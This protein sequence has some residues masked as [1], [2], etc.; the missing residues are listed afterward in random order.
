MANNSNISKG[1]RDRNQQAWRTKFKDVRNVARN[2]GKMTLGEIAP[3][4][5]ETATSASDSLRETRQFISK[6]KN[7]IGYQAN[8]LQGNS[9][10]RRARGILKEAMEDLKS[11]SYGL[12]KMSDES[13]DMADNFDADIRDADS[14]IT[15]TSDPNE[16]AMFETRR[17]SALLGKAISQGNATMV[18]GLGRVTR[19]LSSATLKASQA[20]TDQLTNVFLTS[21]NSQNAQMG[22]VNNKLDAINSN[23]VNIVEFNNS[24]QTEF[25]Q[26]TAEYQSNMLEMMS[27][28]GE[29]IAKMQDVSEDKTRKEDEFDFSRGFNLGTYKNMVKKNINNSM[30]GMIGSVGSMAGMMGNPVTMM[31]P[32]LFGAITP[33]FIKKPIERFD[34]SFTKGMENLLYR[35]NDMQYGD[36]IFSMLGEFLGKERPSIA[37]LNMGNY[38][39]DAMSW[40]GKDHKYLTEVIPSYLAKIESGING[41]PE[42]YFNENKGHFMDTRA[43]RKD[44]QKTMTGTYEFSF[45]NLGEELSRVMKKNNID[46]QEAEAI[47]EM[48]NNATKVAVHS[49]SGSRGKNQVR[50]S[51]M[52]RASLQGKV[53]DNSIAY[54]VRQLNDGINEAVVNISHVVD[55]MET[56]YRQLYNQ[57]G[58][59]VNLAN[60]YKG[61]F[62]RGNKYFNGQLIS[63]IDDEAERKKAERSLEYQDGGFKKKI[64]EKALKFKFGGNWKS[65]PKAKAIYDHLVN[66]K[67]LKAN[68]FDRLS[69]ETY[70]KLSGINGKVD[71][72]DAI[73]A[74][75]ADLAKFRDE[76]GSWAPGDEPDQ[77]NPPGID[78]SAKKKRGKRKGY[79]TNVNVGQNN[80]RSSGG[81]GW[82]AEAHSALTKIIPAKLDKIEKAILKLEK[83]GIST[84]SVSSTPNAS[85][86]SSKTQPT[87][88]GKKFGLISFK[89]AL[90]LSSD[91]LEEKARKT[92][93]SLNG[94]NQ[95]GNEAGP[96]SEN[97]SSADVIADRL[98]ENENSLGNLVRATNDNFMAPMVGGIFG[99]EGM[100][101]RFF[102][103]DNLKSIRDKLFDD[104]DGIFKGVG[105][106]FK[107][108]MDYV[109]YVFTGKGYTNRKGESFKENKNSVFD[110]IANGY[111]WVYQKTMQ[112]LF[113]EDFKSNETYKKHFKRFDFKAKRDAKRNKRLGLTQESEEITLDKSQAT[114]SNDLSEIDDRIGELKE[115]ID[116]GTLGEAGLK[117]AN[118]E[119]NELYHKRKSLQKQNKT[120]DVK[121]NIQEAAFSVGQKIRQAGDSLV[122]NVIGKTDDK[123]IKEDRK[124]FG[125]KYKD[126]FKKFLPV[127]IAGALV[128]GGLG[129]L[130]SIQG[131]GAVAPLFFSGGPIAGAVLGVSATILA[132]SEKFQNVLFGEKDEDGNRKNGFISQKTQNFFKKNAPLLVGG[133]ALGALKGVFK[134]VAG[135]A[136][137][138]G[139]GGF[140]MNSLLPGGI[141][142]GAVLGLG[143]S[144]LKSSDRFT[145]ILF[146]NRGDKNDSKT[147]TSISKKLSE[148]FSKSGHFVK[149]GLKGAAI[150]V[151]SGIALNSMGVVGGALSLGGPVGMG[152]LG[153]GMGIA[154][155]ADRVKEMLFGT[156]EFDEEGNSKGRRKNGIFPRMRNYIVM[157]VFE[158]LKNNLQ[159]KTEDF[160]YWIKRKITYP[161]RLAFG[162]IIDS[163]REVRKNISDTI[164]NVFENVGLSITKAVKSTLGVAFKPITRAFKKVGKTMTNVAFAGA[165]MA[166]MPATLPIN[167]VKFGSRNLRKR[168]QGEKT[169]T[170]V[171]H[172]GDIFRGVRDV[173]RDQWAN[174]DREYMAGPLGKIDRFLTHGRDIFRN[175]RQGI[176]AAKAAYNEGMSAQGFNSLGWMNVKDEIKHD[177]EQRKLAKGDR[178][179][180]KGIDEVRK[181]IAKENSHSNI[182]A[183][184]TQLEAYKKRLKKSGLGKLTNLIQTSDDLNDLLY[185]KEDFLDR[186]KNGD[187]NVAKNAPETSKFFQKT[188]DYQEF[189]MN[190]FDVITKTFM[191]YATQNA[192]SRR[193][194]LSIQNLSDIDK[195][196]SQS[197]LTWEDIDMNPGDLADVTTMSNEDWTTY[198]NQVKEQDYDADPTKFNSL[199]LEILQRQRDEAEKNGEETKEL[200]ERFDSLLDIELA[201]AKL[202]ASEQAGDTGASPSEIARAAGHDFGTKF[203]DPV[204]RH[205]KEQ[206]KAERRAKEA[207]ESEAARTGHKSL[208]DEDEDKKNENEKVVE[209]AEKDK[210]G[211]LSG[212]WS[213][214]KGLMGGFGN[215]LGSEKFWKAAGIGTVAAITF[216]PWVADVFGKIKTFLDPVTDFLGEEVKEGAT[217]LSAHMPEITS[218]LTGRIVDNMGFIV[219]NLW[220]ISST[221]VSTIGKK[222]INGIFH[223][224]GL[225]GPFADAE[226]SVNERQEFES[227]EEAQKFA[228][229]TGKNVEGTTSYGTSEYK[230]DEGNV[231]RSGKGNLV[232]AIGKNSFLYASSKAHRSTR[233]LATL[234]AKATIGMAKFAGKTVFKPVT[235]IFGAGKSIIKNTVGKTSKGKAVSN[236]LTKLLKGLKGFKDKAVDIL[237]LDSASTWDKVCDKTISMIKKALVNHP[238]MA[239]KLTAKVASV[240]LKMAGKSIFLPITIGLAAYDAISG[241]TKKAAAYLFGVDED[242]VDGK[243]RTLSALFKVLSGLPVFGWI[244]LIAEIY[245]QISG[246]DLRQEWARWLYNFLPGGDKDGLKDEID[247]YELEYQKYKDDNHLNTD[248]ATYREI[249]RKN[250][251]NIDFDQYSVSDDELA[252]YQRN[253]YQTSNR[254]S[255]SNSTMTDD[256]NVFYQAGTTDVTIDDPSNVGY[257]VGDTGRR[258]R[259]RVVGYGLS[260]SDPRWANYSLGKFPSGRTSTMATGGCGPT[261][262]SMVA[263]NT[264]PL[265]IA[266][267]AK[268]GGYIKDGGATAD[269][270]T[271][272]AK[273]YGLNASTVSKGGLESALKSGQPTIVSGKSSG[274]GPYTENGHVI[275]AQGMDNKGNTLVNDPM[276]GTRKI[277]TSELSKGMTHGWSYSNNVSYGPG[278]DEVVG[279]GGINMMSMGNSMRSNVRES[280]DVTANKTAGE[281]FK[282]NGKKYK[283]VKDALGQETWQE[284]GFFDSLKPYKEVTVPAGFDPETALAKG[285]NA[286][287]LI[288]VDGRTYNATEINKKLAAGD[289]YTTAK[290]NS[291]EMQGV[292]DTLAQIRDK[293]SGKKKSPVTGDIDILSMQDYGNMQLEQL[294]NSGTLSPTMEKVL[295]NKYG[296]AS[297]TSDNKKLQDGQGPN[298]LLAAINQGTL[299]TE[300][301]IKDKINSG[302]QTT[303]GEYNFN[304]ADFYRGLK[305]ADLKAMAEYNS[306]LLTDSRV[307]KFKALYKYYVRSG[308]YDMKRFLQD[309]EIESIFGR[310]DFVKSLGGIGSEGNYE[311]KYG[312]PFFQTDDP[313]WADISW[314]GTTVK[315]RGSDLASLATI[316]T[317]FGPNMLDP[318]YIYDNWIKANE[319]WYDGEKGLKFDKVFSE[320]GY[321]AQK[322]GH[323][324]GQ[325]VVAKKLMSAN[326]IL[327]YLKANKP[328]IMTGYR[329]RGGPFGGYYNSSSAPTNGP[330]DYSTIVARAANDAQMAV[331]NPFTTLHQKGIFDVHTLNDTIGK[332]KIK[333]VKE[334]YGITGPSGGGITGKVD[335]AS[336][337]NQ[338]NDY[339]DISEASGLDKIAALFKNVAN[340]VSNIFDEVLGSKEYVSIFDE[341]E[342]EGGINEEDNGNGK[343]ANLDGF[344]SANKSENIDKS[345]ASANL[346]KIDYSS[347][348]YGSSTS[349]I[350]NSKYGEVQKFANGNTSGIPNAYLFRGNYYVASGP[351]AYLKVSDAQFLNMKQNGRVNFLTKIPNDLMNGTARIMGATVKPSYGGSMGGTYKFT[352]SAGSP[353]GSK[354]SYMV[355]KLVGSNQPL[356]PLTTKYT[357]SQHP[358]V[359]SNST[360]NKVTSRISNWWNTITS[361]RSNMKIYQGQGLGYGG[362]DRDLIFYGPGDKTVGYGPNQYFEY[363]G[364]KYSI[365]NSGRGYSEISDTSSHNGVYWMKVTPPANI[366][367]KI[368]MQSGGSSATA[369]VGSG[370]YDRKKDNAQNKTLQ[371]I[372]QKVKKGINLNPIE[373]KMYADYQVEN[374]ATNT[375]SVLSTDNL[376]RGSSTSS[377]QNEKYEKTTLNSVTTV[378]NDTMDG[379]AAFAG[380]IQYNIPEIQKYIG[381]TQLSS[382]REKPKY[383]AMHYTCSTSSE[384]GSAKGICDY[385][386]TGVKASADWVVDDGEIWQYN[387]DPNASFCWAVGDDKGQPGSGT[388]LGAT[389]IDAGN[390]NTLSIEMQSTNS[391]GTLVNDPTSSTWSISDAVINNSAGLAAK[392]MNDYSI[393]DDNL[394]MHHH[395]SGKLCPGPW[396]RNEKALDQFYDFK[397]KV[398]A[399][400][401]GGGVGTSGSSGGTTTTTTTTGERD[402]SKLPA[403]V[404]MGAIINA[405][406]SAAMG[407]NYEEAKQHY[408]EQAYDQYFGAPE[409]TTTTETTGDTN[410][411][412]SSTFP[413]GSVSLD[414]GD[415]P[416]SIW[417]YFISKGYSPYGTAGIMGNMNHESGMIVNRKQ[418]DFSN[419]YAASEQYTQAA[420]SGAIDF[421]HDSI[422]YGLVQFTY[423]TLKQ[424]LLD[425]AKA[426]GKSVGDLG[427]Q[428]DEIDSY[429]N[430]NGLAG[431]LKTATSVRE[432]SN[433]FLHEYERPADQSAAVEQTRASAGESFFNQ[434][435]NSSVG[436]GL[437]DI[438]QM[439][440]AYMSRNTFSKRSRAVGYGDNWLATVAATKQAVAATGCTYNK[441]GC[442][443]ITVNGETVSMRQDCSGF[444]GAC[445]WFYG[446]KDDSIRTGWTGIYGPENQAMKNGGFTCL[447]WTGEGDLQP[448]DILVSLASHMEI[449]AG[450]G[451]VYNAGSTDALRAPGVTGGPSHSSYDYVW[452]PGDPGSVDGIISSNTEDSS[453]DNTS[454]TSAGGVAGMNTLMDPFSRMVSGLGNIMLQTIDGTPIAF[455]PG[456]AKKPK[457]FFTNTLNGKITS[458]YGKRSSALGNEFHRGVDIAASKGSKIYSPVSGHIVSKG[459]DVAG[460]GNYAVV[461][462][463]KGKNHLFAHMNKE[464]YYGLGD[465]VNQFDVIGEVGST[466]KSTGDHLHYEIRNNGSKYSTID[467]MKYSY[468]N[469][470]SKSLNIN[471]SN[472]ANYPKDPNEAVGSG[473]RDITPSSIADKLEAASNSEV[474]VDK[475]DAIIDA[476]KVM[477]TNTSKPITQPASSTITQNN[478]TVYGVGDKKKTSTKIIE[479]KQPKSTREAEILAN[480]HNT[481]ARRH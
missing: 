391:T 121:G 246:N 364:K 237:K 316:A 144:L 66:D 37:K 120:S 150:G 466:G 460:Y 86:Q 422:G 337:G 301:K 31:L 264:S 415:V 147:K 173:T 73:A 15:S 323:V 153:L 11:G 2:I 204:T 318:E 242:A 399:I 417:N 178:K 139:P 354:Q 355:P 392:I 220:K 463:Q 334:A 431:R 479:T 248:Y 358:A 347:L 412:G 429:L 438:G 29:S 409:T 14:Q 103:K 468:E 213:G 452:R 125:N 385:W 59:K 190:R 89:Q 299:N 421:V 313:R 462:D 172:A 191:K 298:A 245:Y 285:V 455:G 389:A 123:A 235:S 378:S 51:N 224:V 395:V 296:V 163:F 388:S 145:G 432:A 228:D 322:G 16:V 99:K 274:S 303:D 329:Y 182:Y 114:S 368:K 138:G 471:N 100:I 408:L 193:K 383:L 196:L 184:A 257:G 439:Y 272:G 400:K 53:D 458:D 448:G 342:G 454:I 95:K 461:K 56:S 159:E 435:N 48:I 151:G 162:P 109:K 195:N 330:D 430:A 352:T 309:K 129:L 30:L 288:N 132:R 124:K 365:T 247:R 112:H 305:V 449:W 134:T 411:S 302:Y 256:N 333:A 338:T 386:N 201:N 234:P 240:N 281:F 43:L 131:T 434:Y 226:T 88:G 38:K 396:T 444:V 97:K 13:Y 464:S 202:N 477:V 164:K 379:S 75:E 87:G 28:L 397:K 267:D 122:N 96:T 126:M 45:Q 367:A 424:A 473:S 168:A 70:Y 353:T 81:Y 80:Q 50:A 91:S 158:P 249:R 442:I 212:I 25:Y 208:Q 255:K 36:G 160:A 284:M 472:Q 58:R 423:H 118:K 259:K 3:G 40:N 47:K 328:V 359:V 317:A 404:R 108:Q 276:R 336:K 427:V 414:Y 238:E 314:R 311:Y 335:L 450:P 436:N 171:Q 398:L 180:W 295:S 74:V 250:K 373:Q 4:V 377:S 214:F 18:E 197:G 474:I 154:S 291:K 41:T 111:D 46:G 279:Y 185:N 35:L 416:K 251:K 363:G 231:Y 142:G 370:Y 387:P 236:I 327:S 175:T 19:T 366:V 167:L 24:A 130:G 94:G 22:I 170:L 216:G 372:L 254:S 141:L 406:I 186:I 443:D 348:P 192:I 23:L 384:P 157:D 42:R 135:G 287:N 230:D 239:E 110:H 148:A 68:V 253:K 90:G 381:A 410:T 375:K 102:S 85:G 320:D 297:D 426:E 104:K 156:E 278:S 10:G 72:N 350:Q 263:S 332:G 258:G 211:F 54:L 33:G 346:D 401:A 371:S 203:D 241:S 356:S 17:N 233:F 341:K 105:A 306:A 325:P 146:G 252:N 106:W 380:G 262:L 128:G 101:R 176:D 344:N 447:K 393:P 222:A 133:A 21:M 283:K 445:L 127:G 119:L 292:K 339:E 189:V 55:N 266:K 312:F 420:D 351:G 475:M 174:D 476:L 480:I 282:Y 165:K 199:I 194:N 12:D 376:P 60:Q 308:R 7:Q 390:P 107:D 481:I 315:G 360:D 166:L 321:P 76:D 441:A 93:Q 280:A 457:N 219:D 1:S 446:I 382:G 300:K 271:K 78:G 394:I 92:Q 413:G 161:F 217:W 470:T 63:D 79:N 275:V 8:T 227:E 169:K 83:S 437:G 465:R 207:A 5:T 187:K 405:G 407:D 265:A 205:K 117:K 39:K 425:R 374:S 451:L 218:N 326:T 286:K 433:I 319:S 419:G 403:S 20:Q 467:P 459:N 307:S 181:E 116:R 369:G 61:N 71:V 84:G 64:V 402:L 6:A 210:K 65:N 206:E 289:K 67:D 269:L 453:T 229:L 243:M 440:K 143:V 200:N 357:N 362:G 49:S 9:A 221:M 183:S 26:K 304:R 290:Y 52:L 198:M 179:K 331:L 478:T 188:R 113:G 225:N 345:H 268:S 62:T 232:G 361:K 343:G 57:D 140:L 293:Q 349:T 261:A 277:K 82:N 137:V 136:V 310:S 34:K 418:G 27:S 340:I 77:P 115:K 209:E 260:Q 456:D 69:N 324:D 32:M 155:Q 428:L 294:R 149:G 152:L 44:F 469:D 215:L 270:F 98:L 223:I 244:D 273:K 177:K